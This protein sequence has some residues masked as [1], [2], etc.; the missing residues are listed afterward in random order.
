MDPEIVEAP[1]AAPVTA[2]VPAP[3]PAVAGAF[4]SM[5]DG[6]YTPP[7]QIPAEGKP[8]TPAVPEAGKPVEPEKPVVTSNAFSPIT[9]DGREYKTTEEVVTGMQQSK[10]E[11]IRLNGVVKAMQ[12]ELSALREKHLALELKAGMPVFATKTQEELDLME[13]DDRALYKLEKKQFEEKLGQFKGEHEKQ[14]A[15]MKQENGQRVERIKNTF[16]GM[17]K[18]TEKFPMHKELEPMM[19]HL[20]EVSPWLAGKDDTPFVLYY[21]AYGYNEYKKAVGAKDVT[22]KSIEAAKS[23]AAA[24]AAASGSTAVAPKAPE[25]KV[26]PDS[27]EEKNKR[28]VATMKA[29]PF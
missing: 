10:H 1:S 7:A 20:L 18:N 21:A 25:H 24:G 23:Q 17:R 29:T 8:Q 5:A 28:L 3:A 15:K 16:A 4:D 12:Q 13:P 9:V 2:P 14:L 27:D 26:D 11:G 6:D 22:A 19:S